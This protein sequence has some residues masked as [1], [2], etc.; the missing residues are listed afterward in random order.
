MTLEKALFSLIMRSTDKFTLGVQKKLGAR[1]E[2]CM[3]AGQVI[4]MNS[5]IEYSKLMMLFY[6][7]SPDL[8][9]YVEMVMGTACSTC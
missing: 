3:S 5:G 8:M 1:C 7:K 2:E 9:G 4:A 6:A